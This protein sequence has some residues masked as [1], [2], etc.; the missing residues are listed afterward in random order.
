MQSV[1]NISNSKRLL[2][3][4]FVKT[5]IQILVKTKEDVVSR[6][7]GLHQLPKAIQLYQQDELLQW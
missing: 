7:G 1:F 4:I 6:K 5:F 2:Q 3:F